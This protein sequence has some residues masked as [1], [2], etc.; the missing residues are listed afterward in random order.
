MNWFGGTRS[1]R[2]VG[3]LCSVA[4]AL[5]IGCYSYLPVQSAAPA[6]AE[7]VGIVINDRGRVLLGDRVGALVDRI[8]GRIISRKDG[9]IVLDVYRVTDLRGNSA[10]WT[11]ERVTVPEEAVVGYRARKF[12][13]WKTVLL[14]GAIAFAI[15]TTL[16]NTLNIFGD[17]AN[18]PTPEP[19]NPS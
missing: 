4:L 10:T 6:P 12:S 15:V 17:P 2:A 5:Q 19:P 14:V 1:N 8:D 3:G 18:P 7:Q 16:G 13:K 9:S 11:G